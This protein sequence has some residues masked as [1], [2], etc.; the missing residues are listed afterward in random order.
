MVDTTYFPQY[1]P[2]ALPKNVDRTS[3]P[4]NG[5]S[6][7]WIEFQV[8]EQSNLF[9]KLKKQEFT[10]QVIFEDYQ[11]VESVLYMYLGRLIYAGGGIHPVRRWQRHL[12]DYCPQ[13]LSADSISTDS[14][15]GGREY[16]LLSQGIQGQII[17]REPVIYLIRSV[18]SEVL[19]DLTQ[20]GQVSYKLLPEKYF[21]TPVVTINTEQAISQVWK[22]WQAWQAAKLADRSPNSAP[23]IKSQEALE[24][25]TS[26]TTCQILSQ[27]LN[28]QVTLRDLA[29]EL[30]QDLL[31]LTRS[32][33][34]YVQWGLVDLV[35]IPDLP[36]PHQVSP[37]SRS[38]SS[39]IICV[40]PD[41]EIAKSLEKVLAPEGYELLSVQKDGLEAMAL[42]LD[43]KPDGIFLS[44]QLAILDGYGVCHQLRQIPLFRNKPIFIITA[45]KT[46]KD[47]IRGKMAGVTDILDKA[48]LLNLAI[49]LLD[50]YFEKSGNNTKSG[51]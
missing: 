10:G 1:L 25:R 17:H 47:K 24:G 27:R 15:L 8:T 34:L 29:V 45:Q 28:G 44:S 30:N 37:P 46:L 36:T 39:L 33:M 20:T 11:G 26:P 12:K 40:E 41:V 35:T 13:L 2:T 22:L 43:R 3:I 21:L 5:T 42:C 7:T 19:F 23:I 16:H 14:G 49:P 18:I 9:L 48:N 31:R 32:L 4:S 38:K 50:L 6:S 51:F